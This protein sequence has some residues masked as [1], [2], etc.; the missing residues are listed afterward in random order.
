M[1]ATNQCE[2]QRS[3]SVKVR[4]L[5]TFTKD[6]QQNSTLKQELHLQKSFLSLREENNSVSIKNHL[7]WAPSN[8]AGDS[9][10]I[11]FHYWFSS[12]LPV[13]SLC[14]CYCEH[15]FVLYHCRSACHCVSGC[16]G[17]YGE[18]APLPETT[19]SKNI[20]QLK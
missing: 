2:N 6:T 12:V 13:P 19:E 8:C 11:L 16:W 18:Q 1:L 7:C 4:T 14:V 10:V 15:K 20:Y 17:V 5:S 3:F 9:K